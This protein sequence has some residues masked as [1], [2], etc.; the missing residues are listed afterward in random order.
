MRRSLILLSVLAL[1]A[2]M[3]VSLGC[4]G[5]AGGSGGG[6]DS[7]DA[8]TAGVEAPAATQSDG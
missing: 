6:D 2:F 7:A 4:E 3:S 5:G 1:A 8:D